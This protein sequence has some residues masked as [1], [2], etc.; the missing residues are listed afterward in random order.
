MVDIE[1]ATQEAATAYAIEVLFE[2]VERDR[3]SAW[4]SSELGDRYRKLLR[5]VAGFEARVRE[6]R[7]KFKL[8][9]NERADVYDESLCGVRNDGNAALADAMARAKQRCPRQ[10]VEAAVGD[11]VQGAV[12]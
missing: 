6:T 12:A 5:G 3:P 1:L 4:R 8:G 2:Q 7:V 9:Q 11:P 10:R